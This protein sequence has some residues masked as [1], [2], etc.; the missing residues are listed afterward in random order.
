ME[1]WGVWFLLLLLYLS[2]V[3]MLLYS[4]SWRQYTWSETVSEL[5]NI[6][7]LSVAIDLSS[8]AALDIIPGNLWIVTSVRWS[9][10][11]PKRIAILPWTN[12]RRCHSLLLL[13]PSS[14]LRNLCV[15]CIFKNSS[16]NLH[17]KLL[18]L[19]LRRRAIW[20]EINFLIKWGIV[21]FRAELGSASLMI[22]HRVVLFLVFEFELA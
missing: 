13:I 1:R 15:L 5:E 17:L 4:L 7:R 11:Q 9:T 14:S 16:M 21:W 20:L 8:V 18:L 2:L 3:N 12:R 19:L 10:L 6:S 22:G